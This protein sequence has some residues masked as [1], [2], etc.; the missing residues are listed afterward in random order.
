[1]HVT[2]WY[3]G[4]C[5]GRLE[6][7]QTVI[8]IMTI[9]TISGYCACAPRPTSLEEPTALRGP[10][11]GFNGPTSKGWR[12]KGASKLREEREKEGKAK[13]DGKRGKGSP[14]RRSAWEGEDRRRM[15]GKGRGG[16]RKGGGEGGKEGK[17]SCRYFFFLTASPDYS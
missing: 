10:L 13:E 4:T 17:G 2:V 6:L 7:W 1:M 9:I 14:G 3:T 8:P 11:A 12:G 16:R 15:E 5:F